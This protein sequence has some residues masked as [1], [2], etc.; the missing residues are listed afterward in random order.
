MAIIGI[1][2]EV[3]WKPVRKLNEDLP[4]GCLCPDRAVRFSWLTPQH[5]GNAL[6]FEGLYEMSKEEYER[7]LKGRLD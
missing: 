3:C 6:G 4:G 1:S 7:V 2:C 5:I